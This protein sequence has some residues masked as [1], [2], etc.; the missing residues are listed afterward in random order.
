MRVVRF[1]ESG[2]APRLGIVD[3][4]AP[5]TVLSSSNWTS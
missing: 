1:R 4:D 3:P 2:E 5:T